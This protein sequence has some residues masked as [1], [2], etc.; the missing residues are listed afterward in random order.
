MSFCR[1]SF[2]WVPFCSLSFFLVSFCKCNSAEYTENHSTECNFSKVSFYLMPFWKCDETKCHSA[3]CHSSTTWVA[4]L[5]KHLK[6]WEMCCHLAGD[7]AP[8]GV[9]EP[10][11][12][13][14]VLSRVTRKL[15]KKL[16]KFWDSQNSCQAKKYQH[17]SL[18]WKSKTAVSNHK[19]CFETAY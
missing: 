18:I 13:W 2:W 15:G 12:L 1:L 9:S 4:F 14:W 17:Q 3:G 6:I 5:I 16:S 19:P 7:W 11:L 8:L 10:F